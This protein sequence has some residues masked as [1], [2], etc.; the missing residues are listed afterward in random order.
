M[1]NSLSCLS[2]NYPDFWRREFFYP[3]CNSGKRVA[4]VGVGDLENYFKYDWSKV[5]WQ[6]C[7]VLFAHHHAGPH[8]D[9]FDIDEAVVRRLQGEGIRAHC[10]DLCRLTLPEKYDYI[11]AAD[12]I[13]HTDSPVMFLH[14]LAASLAGGGGCDHDAKRRF[15]EKRHTL[16]V[17]GRKNPLVRFF[18]AASGEPGQEAFFGDSPAQGFSQ[19]QPVSPRLFLDERFSSASAGQNPHP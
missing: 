11:F 7:D 3:A 4:L 17:E 18:P 15:L 13:E 8:Y 9:V 2:P 12:V 14:N 19:H 10:L 6:G 16:W 1:K 5:G